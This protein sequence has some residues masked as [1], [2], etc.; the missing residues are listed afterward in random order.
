MNITD[1]L[2]SCCEGKNL[3]IQSVCRR[4]FAIDDILSILECREF[5]FSSKKPFLRLLTWAYIS[6]DKGILNE[7]YEHFQDFF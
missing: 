1:L 3:Y 2:A 4:I 7:R 5:N 6:N